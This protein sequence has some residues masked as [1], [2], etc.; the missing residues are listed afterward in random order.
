MLNENCTLEFPGWDLFWRDYRELGISCDGGLCL[1]KQM[2]D[3]TDGINPET[4]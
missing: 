3:K 1:I 4:I 2:A